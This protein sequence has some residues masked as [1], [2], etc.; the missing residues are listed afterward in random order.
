MYSY[1]PKTNKQ[2]EKIVC[3]ALFAAGIAIFLPTLHPQTPLPALFQLVSLLLLTAAIS[4]LIRYLMRNYTYAVQ[5][6]DRGGDIPDF[7]ITEQYGKRLT[8]VC[9]VSVTEV[10]AAMPVTEENR[11]QIKEMTKG[12]RVFSYISE[13]NPRDLYLITVRMENETVYLK[14]VADKTLI[15]VL[16][17]H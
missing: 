7:V 17:N 12:K 3:A 8:V 9:R 1:S 10:E 2:R 11:L 15:S 13:I 14:I 6:C 4:V 5:E 16:M